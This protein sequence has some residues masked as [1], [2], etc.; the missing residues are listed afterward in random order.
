MRAKSAYD[1]LAKF[2]F[3]R[4]APKLF[5]GCGPVC[6][7][8]LPENI[9][10]TSISRE[11]YSWIEHIRISRMKTEDKDVRNKARRACPSF[12]KPLCE[13]SGAPCHVWEGL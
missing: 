5:F 8:N 9:E 2:V 7:V 4:Y 10:R 1:I 11:I 13:A 12:T 3:R 6:R